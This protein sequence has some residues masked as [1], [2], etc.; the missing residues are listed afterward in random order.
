ML[1]I[2]RNTAA[3]DNALGFSV[4]S[5]KI[6]H[7]NV[8]PSIIMIVLN[9]YTFMCLTT[10]RALLYIA[11]FDVW[12]GQPERS[13]TSL[14][15]EDSAG[16]F[17]IFPLWYTFTMRMRRISLINETLWPYGQLASDFSANTMNALVHLLNIRWHE[18]TFS[19]FLFWFSCLFSW[20]EPSENGR[21]DSRAT[22][23]RP[24]WAAKF[25]LGKSLAF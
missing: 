22:Y 6:I 16:M 23:P 4:F 24:R 5:L 15:C 12:S 20:L 19:W 18:K 7:P 21:W 25:R 1:T 3:A 2:R 8:Y 10:R 14:L 11:L 9:I 17:S 13:I